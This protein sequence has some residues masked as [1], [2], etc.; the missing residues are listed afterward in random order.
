METAQLCTFFVDGMMLGIDV[1]DVQ[2]VLRYQEM[3]TVPLASPAVTGLINLRG[4]IVT[5]VD[6]RRRLDM[7]ARPSGDLPMNVVVRTEDGAT[8][9]LVDEIG[10]VVDVDPSSREAP[11]ATIRGV[12][13]ELVTDVYKLER[14]LLLVLDTRRTVSVEG[15]PSGADLSSRER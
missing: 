9:L 12:I 8:S 3:T 7:P 11:V 1:R 2:E 10:D 13:R 5:A 14:R 15:L 6:L 4:Q